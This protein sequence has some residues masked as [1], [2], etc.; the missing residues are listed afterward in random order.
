MH[1][2]RRPKE[3]T[4]TVLEEFYQWLLA[5]LN[6]TEVREGRWRLLEAR[7]AWEGNPTW[8]QFICFAWEQDNGNPLLVAVNYGP[9]R[10]QTYLTWPFANQEAGRFLL[11][12]LLGPYRYEREGADLAARGLYLDMPEWGYHVFE[13]KKI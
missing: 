7:A 8:E 10:G 5:C 1:L 6:R 12:D 4:D 11:R 3:T 9:N 13:V 2:G